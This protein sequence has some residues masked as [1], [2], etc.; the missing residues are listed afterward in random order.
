MAYASLLNIPS[1]VSLVLPA[2]KSND[3]TS[4][5]WYFSNGFVYPVILLTSFM[6]GFGQGVA[7]PSSGKYIS[8][9][10]TENNK[11]FFFAFFWSFYMGSQVFGNLIAAFVLGSL[12]QIWYVVIMAS[13]CLVSGLLLFFL[14]PPK[15]CHLNLRAGSS[16]QGSMDN[17][18]KLQDEV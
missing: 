12:D 14:K 16:F 3:L 15:V 9:C 17:P 10:A 7:Q 18:G 11:G 4:T 1:M 13:I 2:L 5:A 8:D 6:N